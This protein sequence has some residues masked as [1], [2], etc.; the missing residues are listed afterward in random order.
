MFDDFAQI[1][2]LSILGPAL[3]HDGH[4]YAGRIPDVYLIIGNERGIKEVGPAN[5]SAE[6]RRHREDGTRRGK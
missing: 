3:F 2:L 6:D 5:G 1:Q 4:D